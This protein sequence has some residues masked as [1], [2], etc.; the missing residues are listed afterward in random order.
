MAD[1]QSTQDVAIIGD[2]SGL[3]AEVIARTDG[4]KAL[5]VD[6]IGAV[7]STQVVDTTLPPSGGQMSSY[8]INDKV[9]TVAAALNQVAAGIDNP[10][11][12]LKNPSGSAKR[13]YLYRIDLG[14]NMANVLSD[15]RLWYAPTVT[16]NGSA[17]T[18]K[19]NHIG[20][21]G[22]SAAQVYTLPTCSSLGTLMRSIVV[23]QN[24]NSAV[25][26]E[27]FSIVLEPN[28]SILVTGNP[29]SNNRPSELTVMW[30]EV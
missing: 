23:G 26:E 12:L 13:F 9:W 15:V 11:L 27:E 29:S 18:P 19:N 10:I 20:G 2:V 21:S 14:V 1:I 4:K 30:V 16:A 6:V 25:I 22:S 3:S 28:T 7:T 24:T 8:A 5:A 17:I